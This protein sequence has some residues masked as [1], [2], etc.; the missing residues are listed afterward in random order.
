MR[1]HSRTS[2]LRAHGCYA[3]KIGSPADYP[4]LSADHDTGIPPLYLGHISHLP[5]VIQLF[6]LASRSLPSTMHFITCFLSLCYSVVLVSAQFSTSFTSDAEFRATVMA[7]TNAYRSQHGVPSVIWN[8]QL[9]AYA[10]T[11]TNRCYW[12]HSVCPL[13]HS[14]S[15]AS[16]KS[17]GRY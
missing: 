2:S 11:W 3:R 13:L 5:I 8:G 7:Y 17:I 12:A 4:I 6:Y 16:Y 10:Q 1:L 14:S 9:A 15:S